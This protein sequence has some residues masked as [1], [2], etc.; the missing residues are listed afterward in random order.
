MNTLSLN[1]NSNL[2][3]NEESYPILMDTNTLCE[4]LWSLFI[5]YAMRGIV[6]TLTS[7]AIGSISLCYIMNGNFAADH[8]YHPNKIV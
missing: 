4:R 2:D 1:S 7:M 3:E 6:I 5:K 8:V